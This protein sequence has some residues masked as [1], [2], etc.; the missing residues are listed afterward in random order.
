MLKLRLPAIEKLRLICNHNE[1]EVVKQL[2][3]DLMTMQLQ[4][5]NSVIFDKFPSE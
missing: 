5:Q 3:L 1:N 2:R 4:Q